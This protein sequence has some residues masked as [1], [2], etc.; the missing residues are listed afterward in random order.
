MFCT[1][2]CIWFVYVL[3][4]PYLRCKCTKSQYCIKYIH[5]LRKGKVKSLYQT[6][7]WADASWSRLKNIKRSRCH[8]FPQLKL[9]VSYKIHTNYRHLKR[10]SKCNIQDHWIVK[11]AKSNKSNKPKFSKGTNEYRFLLIELHSKRNEFC[12]NVSHR[13]IVYYSFKYKQL[14]IN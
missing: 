2:T 5:E 10:M 1:C 3:Y 12:C 4:P 14:R 7:P 6:H 9:R 11:R 8:Y 13:S